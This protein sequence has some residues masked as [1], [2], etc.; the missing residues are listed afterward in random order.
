MAFANDIYDKLSKKEKL[1]ILK[2]IDTIVDMNTPIEI[3]KQLADELLEKLLS[4][5]V[6]EG[7]NILYIESDKN[8][9]Q[10]FN[11]LNILKKNQ[12]NFIK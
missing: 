2:T 5:G 6:F 9:F 10:R 11:P 1:S 7:S 3:S 4:L 12:I 8:V